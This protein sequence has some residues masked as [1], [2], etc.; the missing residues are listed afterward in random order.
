MREYIFSFPQSL[1]LRF[2]LS[3]CDLL[4]L[5]YFYN[6]SSSGAMRYIYHDS[7]KYYKLTYKKIMDDL[8][9][10]NKK[11]R[12][13]REMITNLEKKSLI[14]RF[15][16]FKNQM[17]IFVDYE[18]LF[19]YK[20]LNDECHLAENHQDAGEK[21]PA[22]DNY[23]NN[24]NI[25]SEDAREKE[26]IKLKDR[27]GTIRVDTKIDLNLYTTISEFEKEIKKQAIELCGDV[28]GKLYFSDLKVTSINAD[29]ILFFF[30]YKESVL[31]NF[32]EQFKFIVQ[33]AIKQ[34]VLC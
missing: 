21:V 19:G 34:V 17:Y 13:I 2:N 27:S 33:S 12:Q 30:V 28:V 11:E 6:F 32:K 1:A 15:R 31:K 16:G 18:V 29:H 25:I 5:D 7:K 26:K 9:I 3:L 14:E 20:P 24:L 22:I 8:P 10:L 23:N 4:F